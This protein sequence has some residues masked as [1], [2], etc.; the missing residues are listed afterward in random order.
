[1]K[2]D[3]RWLRRCALVGLLAANPAMAL[4]FGADSLKLYGGDYSPDCANRAAP[5]LR[6][7]HQSL[8]MEAGGSRITGRNV[9]DAVAYFG[10]Q[11][12]PN[13]LT[14]LLSDVPGGDQLLFVVYRDAGGQYIEP[15]A[16]GGKIEA[17]L[18]QVLG[19][20]EKAKFRDCALETHQANLPAPA[21]AAPADSGWDPLRDGKFRAIYR[22]A[23]GAKA[24]QPWLTEMSGPMPPVAEVNV[25]GTRYRQ[26]A[27]CKAH[28]CYDYNVVLLYDPAKRFVYGHLHESGRVTLLGRPSS[29]LAKELERLWRAAWRQ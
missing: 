21:Q 9:Q 25:A 22:K 28:D 8:L 26:I 18:K 10:P 13:Y 4:D 14:T 15:V 11:P 23:L 29:L 6:V 24:R 20:M 27:V 16:A 1:M 17:A 3:R 12:P 7:L 5:R 2:L 19:K